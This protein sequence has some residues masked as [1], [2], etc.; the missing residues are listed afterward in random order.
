MGSDHQAQGAK[1]FPRT[2]PR[3]YLLWGDAFPARQQGNQRVLIIWGQVAAGLL[4][5]ARYGF[6]CRWGWPIRI[7]VPVQQIR[8]VCRGCCAGTAGAGF[9]GSKGTAGAGEQ[10]GGGGEEVAT[11]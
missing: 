1:Q 8:M 3:D 9:V 11:G 10:Q 4:D 2:G 7:F 5:S 6:A